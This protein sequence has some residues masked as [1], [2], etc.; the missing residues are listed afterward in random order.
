M[1]MSEPMD[2]QEKATLFHYFDGP[3]LIC[4]LSAG[5]LAD[6]LKRIKVLNSKNDLPHAWDAW[7]N[8]DGVA[9]VHAR[10]GA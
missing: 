4:T 2:L 7:I 1:T 5:T 8:A 9:N 6:S 3:K 10:H